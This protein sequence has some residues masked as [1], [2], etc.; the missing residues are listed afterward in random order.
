MDA[1]IASA[2]DQGKYRHRDHR[3]LV[4]NLVEF[5]LA[6]YLAVHSDPQGPRKP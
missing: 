1:A 5:L 6:Q 3:Y 2:Q 4:Q